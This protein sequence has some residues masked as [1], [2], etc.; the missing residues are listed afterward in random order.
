MAIEQSTPERRARLE[1]ERLSARGMRMLTG[2]LTEQGD[3]FLIGAGAA[4]LTSALYSV[5]EGWS[6]LAF[7]IVFAIAVLARSRSRRCPDR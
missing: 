4:L 6:L 2:G 1:Q 7:P 5:I 3:A